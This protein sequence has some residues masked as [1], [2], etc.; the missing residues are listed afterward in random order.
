MAD[1]EI[2]MD[3]HNTTD[4]RKQDLSVSIAKAYPLMIGIALPFVVILAFLYGAT[5]GWD[6]LL[7]GLGT[8]TDLPRLIPTLLIG[9]PL[10]ELIHGLTW[11][12]FSEKGLKDVK[13]GF[14][15]K[16]LTPYAHMKVPIQ[17]HAYRWGALMPALV[18]GLFP[19]AM[20]LWRS[21]GWLAIFGIFYVFAAGG[22]L[23]VLWLLRG[24]DPRALVEDH[25]SR[26][27][28]YVL[29]EGNA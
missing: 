10:H 6:G 27:G 21:D 11:V 15:W 16:T 17:A 26:A 19:Y 7:T 28:C 22:D 5:R 12:I 2:I 18:L 14:Q 23:L 4:D 29:L 24:V 3:E 20:G 1:R 25:P 9:V 8:F 13:F